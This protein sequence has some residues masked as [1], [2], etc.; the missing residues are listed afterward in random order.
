[1]GLTSYLKE[2]KKCKVVLIF[3]DGELS[4]EDKTDFERYTEKVVDASLLFEPNPEDCVKIAVTTPSHTHDLLRNALIDLR[5]SNIRIIKKIER[6]VLRVSP[7][8]SE[9]EQLV[10][11]Q[12]VRSLTLLGWCHY[13]GDGAPSIEFVLNRRGNIYLGLANNKDISEDERAWNTL[14]DEYEFTHVGEFDLELL[15]GLKRGYFD[16]AKIV[17]RAAMLNSKIIE[18]KA[19]TSLREAWKLYHHSFDDNE[20]EFVVKV[21]EAYEKHI[22]FVSPRDLSTVVRIL[23]DI[24]RNNEADNLLKIYM[25]NRGDDRELFDLTECNFAGDITE[26]VKEAFEKK[27]LSFKD[28]RSPDEVLLHISKTNGW[29]PKDIAVLQRLTTKD[30][31]KMFKELRGRNHT[32]I[33]RASLLFGTIVNG[34]EEDRAI[35]KNATEALTIIGRESLFNKIRIEA[36][37]GVTVDE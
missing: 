13:S 16:N 20:A 11:F 24:G 4:G 35:S 27:Y 7:L 36:M 8:L 32:R 23:K 6:L 31:Y 12:A 18:M 3:N 26:D 29:S 17:D 14:L 34:N 33:V 22:K 9:F 37:F 5:I 21:C 1:M 19:D 30:F 15:E 28:T 25:E 2:Q 10:Q